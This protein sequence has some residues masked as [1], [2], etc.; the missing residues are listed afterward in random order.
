MVNIF[1]RAEEFVSK[2]K[3]IEQGD[4][5]LL[6]VSGGPDSVFLFY[7]FIH[8]LK[9]KKIDIKVA[10]IHHHLRK[11]ADREVIFVKNL[12]NKYGVEFFR[13]DI[14]IKE[15]KNIEKNLRE[16]R[17]EKLYEI[18]E[19]TGCNKIATGH[20]LDDHIETFFMNLFRGSGTSGLCG[21]WQ[22]SNISPGSEIFIIRPLLCVEK[23]Q[24]VKYLEENKIEYLID[25]SN[26]SS[27]FFRNKIRNEVIPFLLKY[28]PSLKKVILRTTEILKEDE[29]FLRKY[30]DAIFKDITMKEKN[31]IIIDVERFK[32]LDNSIKRR[33]ASIIYRKIKN[34]P[35]INFSIIERLIKNIEM[36]ENV[37]NSEII[38]KIL[39]GE[40]KEDKS[41]IYRIKVPGE[42]EILDKFIIRS[43]FVPF[44][45]K[46]FKNENKFTGY[47]DFSKIKG[48]IIVRNRKG[49]DRFM[50]LGLNKEKK[51]SRFMIDKKIPEKEKDEILIFE[52]NGKI[53]WVCGYE[54]SEQFK[55]NKNT[56][57]ILKIE[58]RS[59]N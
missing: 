7:F 28:R 55:I 4:R 43:S 8:L 30:T 25:T 14:E 42:I 10:Y 27:N 19:K 46:I 51:L 37:Y 49:G 33:I 34:T 24:I 39:K 38:E 32:K 20:T 41:F 18:A 21:I 56:E 59:K 17:Y 22:K 1:K 48:D 11:E 3:L 23:R 44:S 12:T 9:K 47:F 40:E 15:K 50:P 57:K 31:K 36:G 35:Y 29:I 6:A 5:I 16:K 52:N 26:L 53:I 54:I 13:E 2:N 45:D 58:V